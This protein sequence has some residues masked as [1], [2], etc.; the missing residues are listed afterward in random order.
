MKKID[1]SELDGVFEGSR[2]VTA[3]TTFERIIEDQIRQ[4]GRVPVI[5]KGTEWIIR[6][7]E[8]VDT[9]DFTLYMYSVYVGP[10]KALDEKLVGY[11]A[12]KEEL[13]YV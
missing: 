9:Y 4:S 7:N 13:V 8:E 12:E 3:R 5:D 10:R 1:R 6:W 2:K 11:S